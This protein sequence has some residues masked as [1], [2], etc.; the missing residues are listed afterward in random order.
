MHLQYL[1]YQQID[2]QK[3]DNC[4][5]NSLNP[6][7][8]AYSWYLDAATNT[9]DA[10]VLNDYEAVLPLPY[11]NKWG[12]QSV[13]APTFAQQLGIFSPKTIDQGL[14]TDFLK[15]IPKKFKRIRLPIKHGQTYSIQEYQDYVFPNYELDLSQSYEELRKNY[16]QNTIRNLKKVG[17]HQL[18]LHKNLDPSFSVNMFRETK[19]DHLGHPPSFYEQILAIMNAAIIREKGWIWEMCNE[20]GEACAS[21]FF[22][23]DK[24]QH[25]D[26]VYNLFPVSNEE[27][28]KK[29]A[30]FGIIDHVIQIYAG[31]NTLLDFEGSSVKGVAQFYERF[32]AVNKIYRHIDCNRMPFYVKIPFNWYQQWKMR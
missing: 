1:Q 32:G 28:R 12:L 17:K 18:S 3:W 14:F 25:Q 2:Q 24:T 9:W 6:R 16:H 29:G 15:A 5:Q 4:I 13:Y 8:Y 7:V 11:N 31:S 10:I 27:G 26:R 30:M 21:G 23:L 20:K 22:V 19:G